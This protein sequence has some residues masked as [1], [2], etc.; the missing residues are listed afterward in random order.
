[1]PVEVKRKP[2][3]STFSLLR[4]FQDRIKKSRVVV[5][6]KKGAHYEKKK[7]TRQVKKDALRRLEVRRKK[8]Y[9]EKIGKLPLDNS[10]IKIKR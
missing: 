3:E 2:N 1:M 5:L 4:R 10:N 7:N 6:A 8:E 9:L